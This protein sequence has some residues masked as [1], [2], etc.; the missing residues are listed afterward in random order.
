[1]TWL[2]RIS[3]SSALILSLEAATVSGSVLLDDS[4]EA[5][6]RRGRDYSGVVISLIRH[7]GIGPERPPRQTTARMDQR[8]KT[9]VPHILAVE[10]G[11]TVEFPN[12]DPIF[13]NAFSNYDGQVF[14]L[15]LYPPG[16]T[17]KVL[18][19]RPG[20]VRIFCNIHA[21]MSAVIVVLPTPWFSVTPPSGK[22]AIAGV[23]PGDYTMRVFHERA[24]PA[25]LRSLERR[26]KVGTEDVSLGSIRVS[27]AGYLVVPHRNKYGQPYDPHSEDIPLYPAAR[28]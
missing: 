22:F 13:H 27:E 4:R 2:W 28:K 14:D 16:T 12:S 5:N 23:P 3:F 11:T 15:G 10:V 17:K 6:V 25:T 24:T 19:S 18:F 1:M 9:F 21:S 7:G 20:E 8:N 26:I